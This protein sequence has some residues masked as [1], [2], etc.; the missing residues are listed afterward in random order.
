MLDPAHA[1]SELRCAICHQELDGDPDDQRYA[2]L[3]PICGECYRSQQMDDE[4]DAATLLGDDDD[5]FGL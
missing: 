4:I 1:N 3:G 5:E 2:P